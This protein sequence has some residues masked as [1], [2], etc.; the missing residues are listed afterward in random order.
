MYSK[1]KC[2]WLPANE[3][4]TNYTLYFLYHERQKA[5]GQRSIFLIYILEWNEFINEQRKIYI[6]FF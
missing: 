1:E 2:R 5:K 6:F 3:F 4:R